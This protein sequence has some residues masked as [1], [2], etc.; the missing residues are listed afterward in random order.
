MLFR[1]IAFI[2][3]FNDVF[4]DPYL[5]FMMFFCLIMFFDTD[6]KAYGKFYLNTLKVLLILIPFILVIISAAYTH[7]NR[8][9]SQSDYDTIEILKSVD[10]KYII[11]GDDYPYSY[12]PAIYSYAAVYQGKET[13][14]GWATMPN[15]KSYFDTVYLAR[16]SLNNRDC[17]NFDKATAVLNTTNFIGY[18]EYCNKLKNCRLELVKKTDKVCLY[19]K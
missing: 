11:Y 10:G 17:D 1:L 5:E 2:P 13:S 19:V 12:P 14:L 16:D 6:I 8:S 4:V 18:G 7:W 9:Y 15:D 3:I